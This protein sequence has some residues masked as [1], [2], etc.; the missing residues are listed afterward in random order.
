VVAWAPAETV[1]HARLAALS[2]T[3]APAAVSPSPATAPVP[4]A[5]KPEDM[6]KADDRLKSL[7]GGAK[8]GS[9]GA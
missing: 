3:P 5:M 9:E 4:V 8:S 7:L 6:A 2:Q 1:D